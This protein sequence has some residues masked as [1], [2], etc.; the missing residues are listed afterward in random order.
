MPLQNVEEYVK[1][2]KHLPDV[3]SADELVKD[4]IDLGNMEAQLMK[5][6]EELTL[7]VIDQQKQIDE[8]KKQMGTKK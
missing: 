2:N 4:G 1:V 3:Q 6:I 5:K 8:L 7:Y